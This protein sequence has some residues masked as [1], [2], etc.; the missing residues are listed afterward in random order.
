M[1]MLM[2]RRDNKMAAPKG[3]FRSF[4]VMWE[5][6]I[7]ASGASLK[8]LSRAKDGSLDNLLEWDDRR[9]YDNRGSTKSL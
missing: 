4:L 7:G 8:Y 3:K 5:S 1:H 2:R 9:N 6:T